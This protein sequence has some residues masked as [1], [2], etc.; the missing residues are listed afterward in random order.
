M[1][2]RRKEQEYYNKEGDKTTLAEY[3]D[4]ANLN[5]HP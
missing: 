1:K 4:A 2:M 5:H 3:D